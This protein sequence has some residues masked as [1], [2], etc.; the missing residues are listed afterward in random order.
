MMAIGGVALLILVRSALGRVVAILG[1]IAVTSVLGYL[2]ISVPEGQGFGNLTF[3]LLMVGLFTRPVA[4]ILAGERRVIRDFL[5]R[6]LPGPQTSGQLQYD[7]GTAQ[8]GA[9]VTGSLEA[10]DLACSDGTTVSVSARFCAQ[11]RM[12]R[13]ISVSTQ[14]RS[15]L[16][17]SLST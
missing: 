5:R 8:P 13:W 2:A 17:K 15:L 12:T 3:L 1:L 4:F 7:A 14:P 11:A 10:K 9:F 6:C 16:A